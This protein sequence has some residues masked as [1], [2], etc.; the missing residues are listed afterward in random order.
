MATRTIVQHIDDLTGEAGEDVQTVY[1]SID[2]IDYEVDLTVAHYD[3]LVD[4]LAPFTEVARQVKHG[5]GNRKAS[6]KPASATR[7]KTSREQLNAIRS[8]ARAAGYQVSD[9]GRIPGNVHQAFEAA[10]QPVSA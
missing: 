10:H 6:A 1:F 4:A 2:S 7:G 5:R 3:Q 9:R 8:W